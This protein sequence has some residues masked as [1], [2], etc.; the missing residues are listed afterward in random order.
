MWILSGNTR[1]RNSVAPFARAKNRVSSRTGSSTSGKSPGH[2]DDAGVP[3]IA[4]GIA[5]PLW[6]KVLIS[7][8][9]K[10]VRHELRRVNGDADRQ[11]ARDFRHVRRVLPPRAPLER[12]A[13]WRLRTDREVALAAERC[14]HRR[15]ESEARFR[16]VLLNHDEIAG[17]RGRTDR[18][19]RRD[20]EPDEGDIGIH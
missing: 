20:R 2:S 7:S 3:A 11:A 9:S 12:H 1:T 19:G 5:K 15:I 4:A 13:R 16:R 8:V 10:S 6:K 18:R 17:T 14:R